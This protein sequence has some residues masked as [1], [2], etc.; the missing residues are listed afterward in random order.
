MAV[1]HNICTLSLPTLTDTA[2]IKKEKIRKN[3]ISNKRCKSYYYV[4]L[5]ALMH[6][7]D[8]Q[9]KD[10]YTENNY[11]YLIGSRY[12]K[13]LYK[14][15]QH[16]KY[17]KVLVNDFLKSLITSVALFAIGVKLTNELVAWRIF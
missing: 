9:I 8:K 3:H 1:K 15:L 7:I 2:S 13:N 17:N 10:K 12:I 16:C 14:W 11:L 4:C 5:G 6:T